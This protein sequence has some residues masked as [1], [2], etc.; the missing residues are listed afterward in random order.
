MYKHL[1]IIPRNCRELLLSDKHFEIRTR[2]IAKQGKLIIPSYSFFS[3]WQVGD[4]CTSSN[5]FGYSIAQSRFCDYCGI[6]LSQNKTK[7]PIRH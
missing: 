5:N 7:N 1:C 6:Y 4:Q 3:L 2:K